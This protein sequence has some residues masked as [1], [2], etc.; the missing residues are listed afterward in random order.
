MSCTMPTSVVM[1]TLR[2]SARSVLTRSAGS[3]CTPTH[4]PL[5]KILV[6][7]GITEGEI[8]SRFSI[9][10]SSRNSR[11]GADGDPTDTSAMS[12]RFF[13]SPTAWPSGV[14]AG[15]T[16]PQCELWSWRGLASLPSRPIGELRRR[17]WLRVEEKD[18]RLSTCDTPARVSC[19]PCAPQLPVER[20]YLSPDVM[21]LALTASVSWM[22]FPLSTHRWQY[23]RTSLLSFRNSC[24]NSMPMRGPERSMRLLPKW[25][26]SSSLRR[27]SAHSNSRC[28]IYPM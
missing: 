12:D 8:S 14:S 10:H 18:R 28:T 16:M 7:W 6:E 2:R 13:T 20:E 27:P 17:R 9:V 3:R 24:R 22:S 19:A 4:T 23:R 15:H 21:V 11:M 25:S 5:T 1:S 26:R